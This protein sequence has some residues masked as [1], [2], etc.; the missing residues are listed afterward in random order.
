[1][2]E[3]LIVAGIGLAT[4]LFALFVAGPVLIVFDRWVDRR[5][6]RR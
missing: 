2:R 5:R 3:V 1:M 6:Q 4:G